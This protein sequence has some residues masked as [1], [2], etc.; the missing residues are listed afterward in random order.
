M[1][2]RQGVVPGYNAQAMVS[3]LSGKGGAAGVLVTAVEV[4]DEA[5]D[6]AQLTPMAEQVEETTGI[7]VPMTLADAGY[8][9]GKHVAEFHRRGQQ[10]VMPDLARPTNH[11]YHK[12]QF[13][14][15]DKNDS[16]ICPMD[17][18]LAPPGSRTTRRRHGCTG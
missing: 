8:F 5:N 9:A 15:D 16:Y 4:V 2:T 7:R 13:I 14:Y 11:P 17:R 3:P 12:D 1:Q 10:V 18:G 6:A